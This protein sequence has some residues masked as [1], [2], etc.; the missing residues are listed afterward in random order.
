M[1]MLRLHICVWLLGALVVWP[2][3]GHA[4]SQAQRESL[5]GLDGV[6]VLVEDLNDDTKRAGLSV[7][8]IKTDVELKLRKAGIRITTK[9]E[10][11]TQEGPPHLYVNV[12]VVG[13]QQYYAYNIS[14][15]LK[16]SVYLQR[17]F[18]LI[19]VPT[20]TTGGAGKASS[21]SIREDARKNLGDFVDRFINDYLAVNSIRDLILR[22]QEHLKAVGY[23]PGPVDGI[24][25]NRTRQA[26]RQ[27]QTDYFLPVTGDLDD[28]TKETMGLE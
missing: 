8:Q 26:L 12:N 28:A 15:N 16:Q 23:K 14:V 2:M 20:W 24:I 11:L 4:A 7:A 25:G 6:Y 13:S 22:A 21:R 18:L 27:Y 17:N 1:A 3:V 10:R 19:R 9:E 5:R